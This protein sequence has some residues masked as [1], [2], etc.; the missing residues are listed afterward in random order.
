MPT[1]DI[2]LNGIAKLL[3]MAFK[4]AAGTISSCH[5]AA[6]VVPQTEGVCSGVAV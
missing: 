4:E 3:P 1:E 6:I 2:D 5:L